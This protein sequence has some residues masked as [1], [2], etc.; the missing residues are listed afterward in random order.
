[1]I[2][3]SGMPQGQWLLS[4]YPGFVS[5]TGDS[6]DLSTANYGRK[7]V[8]DAKWIL[9]GKAAIVLLADGEWGIWDIEGVG[10]KHGS[11]K[12][13]GIKGGAC[14]PFTISGFLEG[15]TTKSSS[16]RSAALQQNGNGSKFV[17]MT[18]GTRRTTE[19][20]LFGSRSSHHGVTR[21]QL[22]VTR[23]PSVSAA[24]QGNECVI[25]WLQESYAVI[26]NIWSF[27]DTQARK[28][29]GGASSTLFG[30]SSS[31][32]TRMMKLESVNLKGERCT[33]IDYF[34]K[35]SSVLLSKH[36]VP[37][38][39]L[40]TGE[41]RFVI[42]SDTR[43]DL[44]HSRPE[45]EESNHLTIAGGELDVNSIDQALSQMENNGSS[46]GNGVVRRA[47]SFLR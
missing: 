33:C 34:P 11:N 3:N 15:A 7:S 35:D 38:D 41:R 23:L 26:P 8:I 31:G 4:L 29:E 21:G 28:A 13:A 42:A 12:H 27:W 10:P 20:T 6:T 22:V 17:P 36:A 39:I 25:L 1:L 19:P 32:Y 18:P 14:T 46:N 30:T 24:I 9:S 47:V 37:L 45:P 44:I 40:V 16:G 5:A 2:S 43:G